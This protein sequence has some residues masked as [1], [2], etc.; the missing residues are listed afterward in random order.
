MTLRPFR[1]P[2]DLKALAEIIP[3]A[4]QYP[5]NDAWSMRLEEIESFVDAINGIRRI[6]SLFLI[7]AMLS[8]ALRWGRALRG[9]SINTVWAFT[10]R[11][12]TNDG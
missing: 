11:R 2:S 3:P 12:A 1:L 5:E 10:S 9:G 8:P 7:V 6:W 4:F